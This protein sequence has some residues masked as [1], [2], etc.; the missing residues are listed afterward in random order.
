MTELGRAFKPET[1]DEDA[2][3]RMVSVLDRQDALPSI[4]RLRAWA[5]ERAAVRPGERA[6]D[7]GSGTGT[8]ARRLA[9]A[10]GPGGEAVGVEPN[11]MLRGVAEERAAAEGSAAV[12]C[13][14]LATGIPLPDASADV[15]W[16]ERVLQHLP[17]PQA[18]I[19]EMTRVLRPGGRAL[20]LDSD[21]GSRVDSD[22]EPRVAH[23]I[24]A[25]FMGQLANPVAARHVPRQAMAAGLEVDADVGSSALVFPQAMLHES[26]LLRL[27]AD[28][29]VADGTITREE[30]DRA[31]RDQ[32]D[33]AHHHWAFSAVTV[34]AFVC[35]R[36]G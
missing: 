31:V 29:A 12:F 7:V 23:A 6:V 15:V 24:S 18:A 26:P 19:G 33:A 30:A 13:Q 14:G 1:I 22:I 2:V 20:L 21:H 5:L 34:F 36:P 10:V 16:C 8:M 9:A 3:R 17:D 4:Q 35:R 25:A 28:Q 27:A 11:G 32:S